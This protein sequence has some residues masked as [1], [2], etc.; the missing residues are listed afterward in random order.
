MSPTQADA[1][2]EYP[3][4]QNLRRSSPKIMERRRRVRLRVQWPVCIWA[5]NSNAP[6]ETVTTD[7]S[8][9]GFHCLSPAPLEPDSLF[10]CT[11]MIP[12]IPNQAGNGKFD[13]SHLTKTGTSASAA[14][15]KTTASQPMAGWASLCSA[16]GFAPGFNGRPKYYF[17]CGW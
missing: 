17:R 6:V 14:G 10:A 13:S 16:G 7:L 1:K 12:E 8:S 5:S 4:I 11:L 15:S 9:D 2:V 3:P